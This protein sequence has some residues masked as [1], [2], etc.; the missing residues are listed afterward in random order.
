MPE[1]LWS[2]T[3]SYRRARAAG[4]G[5]AAAAAMTG[6]PSIPMSAGFDDGACTRLRA[7][8]YR[9]I[10]I[11]TRFALTP[12][13]PMSFTTDAPGLKQAFTKSRLV[14]SL[15]ALSIH[16]SLYDQLRCHTLVSYLVVP[17]RFRMDTIFTQFLSVSPDVI[18]AALT[19]NCRRFP[20]WRIWLS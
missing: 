8:Q 6:M 1:C 3:N 12:H 17:K 5:H 2:L 4:A 20:S 10:Q 9:P 7:F 14:S 15:T 19:N 16:Q 18:Y 13:S 11:W